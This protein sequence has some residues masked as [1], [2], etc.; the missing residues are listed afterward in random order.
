LATSSRVTSEKQIRS[1]FFSRAT[2][3][4]GVEVR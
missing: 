3:A 1:E 4:G 2:T